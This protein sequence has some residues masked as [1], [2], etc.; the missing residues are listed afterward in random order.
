[1]KKKTKVWLIV[2]SLVMV[3]V[4]VLLLW[5]EVEK[6]E[7]QRTELEQKEEQVRPLRLEKTQLQQQIDDLDDEYNLMV[8]KTGTV[9]VLFTDL[10]ERIYTDIYPM[11]KEYGFVGMLAISSEYLPD[12]EGRLT[13]EQIG[14]L[15]D[16]GW[17]CCPTWQ[18]GGSIQSIQDQETVLANL[19]IS[20]S[21]T[22]YF[23]K[24]AY[25]QIYDEELAAAGYTTAIHHGEEELPLV[26]SEVSGQV[27]HPGAVG[28]QGKEPRYRLEDAVGERANI[29]FTV[30]YVHE[31]EMYNSNPFVSMLNYLEDYSARS[32]LTVT[33]PESAREYFYTA[34]QT[35]DEI[36][37]EYQQKREEL[38]GQLQEIEEQIKAVE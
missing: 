13:S 26:T 35:A 5:T 25:S 16:A 12:G 11:M 20:S 36:E 21:H 19:G 34:S 14:E 32:E 1:M 9:T 38:E 18:T 6:Q 17:G 10:D 3:C 37:A 23:E 27:W 29:I 33:L 7:R 24:G 2:L 8:S 15:R 4:L 30:S 28:L 31:E 22:V